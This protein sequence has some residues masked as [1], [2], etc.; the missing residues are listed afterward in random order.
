MLVLTRRAGEA[1]VLPELG[2]TIRV[3]EFGRTRSV[4]LGV[5]APRSVVVMREELLDR[6]VPEPPPAHV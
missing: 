5:E 6:P 3:L 2:I 1:I 4:R